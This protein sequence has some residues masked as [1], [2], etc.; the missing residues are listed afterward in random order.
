MAVADYGSDPDALIDGE[1]DLG[2]ASMEQA[3][4]WNRVYDEILALEERV[5]EP[6]HQA[7]SDAPRYQQALELGNVRVTEPQV[8]QYRQRH[9]YWDLKVKELQ[10]SEP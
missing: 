10:V 7:A 9:Q 5:M 2:T 6:G 1:A 4:F 8:E 3:L